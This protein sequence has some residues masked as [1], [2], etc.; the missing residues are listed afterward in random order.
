MNPYAIPPLISCILAMTMGCFVLSRNVRSKVNITFSLLCF[1]VVI[2][3]SGYTMM[4][5][6]TDSISALQWARVGF[7]G[8]VFI[9]FF[10]YHFVTSYINRPPKGWVFPL[11]YGLGMLSVYLGQTRYVYSGI[12]KYFWGYYPDA[13]SI[14]FIFPTIYVLLFSYSAFLL[15]QA[16]SRALKAKEYITIQQLRYVFLAS[17][18]A[19]PGVV[20]YIIK[21]KIE[22]Y[23]FGYIFTLFFIFIMTY[24]IVKT[25]L[26]DIEIVIRKG[27]IYSSL[28]ASLTAIYL[29]AIFI[30]GNYLGGRKSVTSIIFTLCAILFFSLIFQPLRDRIQEMIDRTFFKTKYDHQKTLKELSRAARSILEIDELLNKVTTSIVETIKAKDVLI[31]VLDKKS[32]QFLLRRSV[33]S[34]Q[35]KTLGNKS[36][37]VKYLLEKKEAILNDG[38]T[39]LPEYISGFIGETAA[40]LVFPV[41]FKGELV[42]I[43]C[44]GEKLS[45]DTYSSEDIDLLTTLC[46]QIGISIKN[47]MLS[48][49]AIET[50]KQLFQSDKLATIGTLAAGLVH[51]IKNPLTAIKGFSQLI[52]KAFDERDKEAIKEYEGIMTRQLDRIG[53]IVE[54]LL[55]L[56]KPGKLEKQKIDVNSVLEDIIKLVGKQAS[57][58]QVQIVKELRPVSG[59]TADPGQLT[60]AFLN[61]ILNGI[62]AMPSGGTLEIKTRTTGEGQIAVEII[63]TGIGIPKDKIEKIFDPFYTTK[64]SGVGL[65]LAVTK[66]IID[67]HKGK[68]EVESP[69]PLNELR[70]AGDEGK[71]TKFTVI[72]PISA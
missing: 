53:E 49:E 35:Q 39:K 19:I 46:D 41:L 11:F 26:M 60:Q 6:S 72:L 55:N 59:I 3:L 43:F 1:S 68:I 2:W 21:Y 64:E 65:G 47:S 23:P 4:Y 5:I 50:Q 45:G 22:I 24:A 63:D 57:S 71:G 31:Y 67:D 27:L 37:I 58:H 40:A 14:Y 34:P 69:P 28:V 54:K 10:A 36:G 70:R 61:L 66:K 44:L 52:D 16:Y 8:I 29:S 17:A 48:E 38:S 42:G 15:F 56:S 13:G 12:S 30:F 33:I 20:D 25:R 7:C 51:E 9:P 62:Q 32:G 18:G